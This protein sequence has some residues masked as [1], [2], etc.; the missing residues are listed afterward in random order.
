MEKL[1]QDWTVVQ[2]PLQVGLTSLEGDGQAWD[3]DNAGQNPNQRRSL[4]DAN[5]KQETDGPRFL[6]WIPPVK[7]FISTGAAHLLCGRS[8]WV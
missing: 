5:R 6:L 4:V 1:Y 2:L 7:R 3:K 8:V